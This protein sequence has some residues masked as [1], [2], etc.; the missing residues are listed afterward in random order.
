MFDKVANLGAYTEKDAANVM[1]Q[2]LAAVAYLH[3]H[4]M[5]TLLRAH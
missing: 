5:N 4:G 3:E 1:R 2:V